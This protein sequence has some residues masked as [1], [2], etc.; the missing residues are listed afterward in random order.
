MTILWIFA[1][2]DDAGVPLAVAES[3]AVLET[4]QTVWTWSKQRQAILDQ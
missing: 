4:R 2:H 1:E 3:V